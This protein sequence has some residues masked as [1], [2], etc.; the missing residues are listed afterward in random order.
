M[1]LENEENDIELSLSDEHLKDLILLTKFPHDLSALVDCAN[2]VGARTELA[3][4]VKLLAK[5]LR[6]SVGEVWEVVSPLLSIYQ[7]QQRIGLSTAKIVEQITRT[8]EAKASG[9]EV[10]AWKVAAPG[11]ANAVSKLSPDH[12]LLLSH[13]ASGVIYSHQNVLTE[14]KVF[15]DIRPV[16]NSDGT[17]I[18]QMV[19]THVLSLVY[20]DGSG[21][22]R[23]QIAMD[24]TDAEDLGE[25][26]GRAKQ[27]ALV[28]KEQFKDKPWPTAILHQ[29]R[30]NDPNSG[31]DGSS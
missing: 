23:I 6:T 21:E 24:A 15:T 25:L 3:D 13:K 8:F 1:S 14:A 29:P 20:S 22:R 16:F 10:A 12:P 5:K 4:L 2:E 26:C 31:K 19:V 30:R 11:L 18:I 9:E 7:T 28:V 27:K 17:V